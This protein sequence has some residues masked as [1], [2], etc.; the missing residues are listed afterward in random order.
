VRATDDDVYMADGR[1][2]RTSI[3]CLRRRDLAIYSS[4]AP[5]CLGPRL[6]IAVLTLS[7]R[8]PATHLRVAFASR[9]A[10]GNCTGKRERAP[11][12]EHSKPWTFGRQVA[13]WLSGSA[14]WFRSTKLLYAAPV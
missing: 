5:W 2:S 12:I 9:I 10:A 4:A 14:R 8:F 1:V 11:P 6:N 3:S 13:G 7:G